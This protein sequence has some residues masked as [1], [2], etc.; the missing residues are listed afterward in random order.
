MNKKLKDEIIKNLEEKLG[1]NVCAGKT[2]IFY[3]DVRENKSEAF[4]QLFFCFSNSRDYILL[5]KKDEQCNIN[6]NYDFAQTWWGHIPVITFSKAFASL[7]NAV[8]SINKV[9]PFWQIHENMLASDSKE[10]LLKS[11]IAAV[12]T[13]SSYATICHDDSFIVCGFDKE[14]QRHSI[15]LDEVTE[16]LKI[17]YLENR[18]LVEFL[19]FP[20][21]LN[22]KMLRNYS[23][24]VK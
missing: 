3:T 23:A 10:A 19:L 2:N 8:K 5:E 24:S 12:N 16:S 4:H 15:Y 9:A 22:F 17:T 21:C 6:N 11:L 18:I 13:R 7:K 14:Y 1:V 20:H